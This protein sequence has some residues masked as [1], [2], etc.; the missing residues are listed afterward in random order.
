PIPVPNVVGQSG[1]AAAAALQA[2]GF[3]VS[4]IEGSPSSAVLAT[5]PPA[6]EAH[7]AGTPV[8]IF[9]RR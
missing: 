1:T 3:G 6:G 7:P 8:R 4:G 2:A 9:T 5:D